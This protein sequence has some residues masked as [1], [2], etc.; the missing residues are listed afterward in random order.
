MLRKE[1]ENF[2]VETI[3]ELEAHLE[4][5]P[6]YFTINGKYV[7]LTLKNWKHV[8]DSVQFT[9]IPVFFT[10]Q[11]AIEF[12]DKYK[13][14]FPKLRIIHNATIMSRYLQVCLFL[15][16]EREVNLFA[17]FCNN[18]P[19]TCIWEYNGKPQICVSKVMMENILKC[20]Q[21][22]PDMQIDV[23]LELLDQYL[24][25]Y[26][27]RCISYI[28]T[29]KIRY[30]RVTKNDHQILG[31][32]EEEII[33]LAHKMKIVS[34]IFPEYQTIESNQDLINA[35]MDLEHSNISLVL[36]LSDKRYKM[37]MESLIKIIGHPKF[38]LDTDWEELVDLL[39]NFP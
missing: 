28:E 35:I 22:V 4:K 36:D 27:S 10:H 2:E 5:Y 34:I 26:K 8:S 23:F 11:R 29:W 19:N 14:Q 25:S 9:E 15:S 37:D 38:T 20:K 13:R 39:E 17:E 30:K 24:Q 6:L 31:K 7:K 21:I 1:V 12:V 18:F 3:E 33:R 32:S 16:T